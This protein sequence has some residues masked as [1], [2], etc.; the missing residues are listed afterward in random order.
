MGFKGWYPVFELVQFFANTLNINW[1]TW[2]FCQIV[3]GLNV[4]NQCRM[5]SPQYI[6]LLRNSQLH[7]ELF[8]SWMGSQALVILQGRALDTPTLLKAFLPQGAEADNKKIQSDKSFLGKWSMLNRGSDLFWKICRGKSEYKH[9]YVHCSFREHV[10][11]FVYIGIT[12]GYIW[13]FSWN[14]DCLSI[15]YWCFFMLGLNPQL[16]CYLLR[17]LTMLSLQSTWFPVNPLGSG[18]WW[19]FVFG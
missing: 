2:N 5:F 8:K 4:L 3:L 9:V 14:S 13:V 12:Q 16:C 15:L 17:I 6:F 18:L 7:H 1:V 19:W 11:L 10:G